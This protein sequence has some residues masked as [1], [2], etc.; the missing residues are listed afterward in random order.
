MA[1]RFLFAMPPAR[2][3]VCSDASINPH[4]K[5]KVADIFGELT[6][7]GFDRDEKQ[8]PAKKPKDLPSPTRRGP[9]SRTS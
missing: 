5:D 2:P 3:P 4:T 1:A 6:A 8:A 9:R 7:L